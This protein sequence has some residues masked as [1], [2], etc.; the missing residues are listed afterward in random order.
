MFV[1]TRQPDL[2]EVDQPDKPITPVDRV[3][4]E[5]QVRLTSKAEEMP[6]QQPFK[7]N[8]CTILIN[9]A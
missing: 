1:T 7:M 4:D 9:E 5:G 2:A 6:N 8:M 3:L